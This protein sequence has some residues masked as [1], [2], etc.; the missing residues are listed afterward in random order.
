MLCVQPLQ[1]GSCFLFCTVPIDGKVTA[2]QVDANGT[3]LTPSSSTVGN[4]SIIVRPE[5]VLSTI[6]NAEWYEPVTFIP[7]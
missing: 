2:G 1:L 4:D 3:T 7:G 6:Y 5:G